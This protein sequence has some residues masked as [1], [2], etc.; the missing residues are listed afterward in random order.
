M[1]SF[2]CFLYCVAIIFANIYYY[3]VATKIDFAVCDEIPEGKEDFDK[4]GTAEFKD[5]NGTDFNAREL[6][7]ILLETDALFI[8]MTVHTNY[9]SKRNQS[10]QVLLHIH[11]YN[12]L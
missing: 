5:N 12:Y 8:K 2:V 4:L 3:F 9:L 7:T 1:N 11:A 6:K 10:N